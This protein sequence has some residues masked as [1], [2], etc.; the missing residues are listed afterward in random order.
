MISTKLDIGGNLLKL[1]TAKKYSQ[2]A[3]AKAIGIK[4]P[5]YCDIEAG[6]VIPTVPTLQ[7]LAEFLEVPLTKLFEGEEEKSKVINTQNNVSGTN[8]ISND[9]STNNFFENK[10]V[11]E[12]FQNALKDALASAMA[13]EIEKLTK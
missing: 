1:R 5:N 2:T 10:D 8:A 12:K 4:Q 6:K 9:N 11:V 3:L 7:K 13:T